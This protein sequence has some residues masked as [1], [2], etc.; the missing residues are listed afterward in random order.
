MNANINTNTLM[1]ET[2][3]GQPIAHILDSPSYFKNLRRIEVPAEIKEEI[4]TDLSH[5][6]LCYYT[7]SDDQVAY[8]I[9][10]L[11]WWV[12]TLCRKEGMLWGE[13]KTPLIL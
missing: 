6:Q 7:H 2:A 12:V 10:E 4:G 8:I 5:V 11:P 13:L 3:N 9:P 1:V